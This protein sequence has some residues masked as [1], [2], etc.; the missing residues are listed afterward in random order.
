M[1]KWTEEEDDLLRQAVSDFG[2]RHN[3]SIIY[4][5]LFKKT[6]RHFCGVIWFNLFSI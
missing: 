2:G 3:L 6:I 5:F 1:G 4:L